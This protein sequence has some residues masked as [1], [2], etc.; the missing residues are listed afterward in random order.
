MRHVRRFAL[1]CAAL[2][3]AFHA[4]PADETPP[5]MPMPV[6]R[7][8]ETTARLLKKD[9]HESRLLDDMEKLDNWKT[10]FWSQG[11]GEIA[12]TDRRKVDGRHSLRFTTRTLGEKPSKDGGVFG[13]SAAVRVF[14]EE[15][16]T[17]Y[18][19]L[20]FHVYPDFPGF[21]AVSIMVRLG[22][23]GR[24]LGRDNHH[25]LV[26]NR[27]WNRVV[28]EIPDLAR[29]K[30]TE[31]G[32]V[33]VM[34]GRERGA[35]E[36]ATF[37]L[38]KL[39]LQRVDADPYEGWGVAK[40]RIAFS[41]TGYP[42]GAAKTAF[43]SGL[44][45]GSFEVVDAKTGKAVLK[46]PLRTEKTPVGTF[47]V[48]EFTEIR[49]YGTYR[50][51]A[52]GIETEPFRID[53]HAW[54][55][56]IWKAINFFYVERCGD[57]IPGVHALCHADLRGEHGGKHLV[58]NGGWHDA[59]DL[60]QGLVNTSESAYAMFALAD[61][62]RER[63]EAP[64][65]RKRLIEEARWG[66]AWVMKTRFPDGARIQWATMRF[67][68][69]CKLGTVDD[70]TTQARR[71]AGGSFYAAAVEAIAARVL[72][73]DDPALA[74]KALAMAR[75]DWRAGVEDTAK[76]KPE[77][78]NIELAS[79]GAIASIELCRA[80]GKKKEYAD[81]ARAFA[82]SI[83]ASQQRAF[84][85][86]LEKPIAGFFH[87]DPRRHGIHTYMHRSHEQ[88]PVVA[89]AALCR[90][91]PDDAAWMDW[92]AA[93][94]LHARYYQQAMAAFTAPYR[95]LP[96]SLRHVNEHKRHGKDRQAAVREQIE[97]G[98]PAGGGY[99]V[100]VYPVQPNAT[101]RGNYGT[102]LSQ[103]KAVS[104][105]AHLR[106]DPALAHLALDQLHWVVGRNPF[107]QSTMVGEGYDFA[108]QYT[109]RSGDIVGALPVGMKSLGNRDLPYWPATN[110]WNYK[111]VWVHPVARWLALM[112]DLEGP[113]IVRGRSAGPVTFAGIGTKETVAAS[114]RGGRFE[115]RLPAGAYEARCG[116][117]R[118][119]VTL[120]PAAVVE[121]DL[122]PEKALDL[123]V[124]RRTAA[125]GK[126]TI[127]LE[128][129]G[130]G[131][132]I[133]I[134]RLHNLRVAETK[135]TAALKPGRAATV[136]WT[137]E[138]ADANAPWVAVVVP[139]GDVT[140]RVEAVGSARD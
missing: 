74:A 13:S 52:G 40:G 134:L 91:F 30:V 103:A 83:V 79:I 67:W 112:E 99:H 80:D 16:W 138:V 130:S 102:I 107:G 123:V 12:L 55:G 4:A 14:K 32:F 139:D 98:F 96:N 109:A 125:G 60:S 65:L 62:L 69:D 36:T 6:P 126:V 100:R 26:E 128:A 70:V 97:N 92:Y 44:P 11:K 9:V 127:A 53:D 46:R 93:V 66:L 57:A 90:L 22:N 8:R 19:R 104:T 3:V 33:Y 140:Q 43:A 106:G 2:P 51:R 45:D 15:D 85:P 28:W 23:K 87:R 94:A 115:A 77:Q 41:H 56:T 137:C 133:F 82:G 132:H 89:L 47:Q 105:A 39:E 68:T 101:F 110:V 124:T 24:R 20:S 84:L 27:K 131:P 136:A 38:D 78:V 37:D 129:R 21:H 86:G 81:R 122:R 64:A 54:R 88:A 59:G 108:P 72:K 7:E 50:L 75:D 34:N 25:V 121:F 117:V 135:R 118:K 48:L 73:D 111:E 119:R 17:A 63:G 76:Q 116:A 113:A 120:L 95:M 29:D 61:R 58:I 10:S 42:A 1:V 71:Q 35:A 18:N 31:V 114:P 5:K 49:A